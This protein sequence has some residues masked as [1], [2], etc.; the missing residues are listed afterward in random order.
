[1]SLS[2]SELLFHKPLPLS[3]NFR[4]KN[5]KSD[6]ILFVNSHM[7]EQEISRI[8]PAGMARL[9]RDKARHSAA[10]NHGLRAPINAARWYQ[11]FFVTF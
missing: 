2:L 11:T 4:L 3:T 1:M 9:G 10:A 6:D 5:E 8:C 7:A